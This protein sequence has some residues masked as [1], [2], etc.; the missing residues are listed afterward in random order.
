M[1]AGTAY[2]VSSQRRG[3]LGVGGRVR[4]R[5]SRRGGAT[6]SPG[7]VHA[8]ARGAL[9]PTQRRAL[10][11]PGG[12]RGRPDPRPRRLPPVTSCC[13]PCGAPACRSACRGPHRHPDP[14]AG[15]VGRHV[16]APGHP[17]QRLDPRRGEP[18]RPASVPAFQRGGHARGNR[19]HVR[20]HV[21]LRPAAV[22]RGTGVP[23]RL[24]VGHQ[25]A[26]AA[27]RSPSSR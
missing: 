2:A 7:L 12:A 6:A 10:R 25:P 21:R 18:A 11:S 20:G 13:R 4:H 22:G 5:P 16:H 27:R 14:P 9:G 1:L 26:R 3:P 17:G 23:R 8:A 24:Q 15:V 19:P